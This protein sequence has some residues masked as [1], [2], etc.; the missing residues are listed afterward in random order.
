MENNQ[1]GVWL[2]QS[3]L[4]PEAL[5]K[6]PMDLF[7]ELLPRHLEIIFEINH[8]FL[9]EVREKIPQMKNCNPGVHH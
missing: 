1:A 4:L 6:W 5:E 9:E 3:Y 2:Y 7:R 8:H